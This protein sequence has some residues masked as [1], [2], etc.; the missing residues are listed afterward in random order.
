MTRRAR[1]STA[2]RAVRYCRFTRVRLVRPRGSRRKGN[3]GH[4]YR[5]CPFPGSPPTPL[6][7]APPLVANPATPLV[8]DGEAPP[9][10]ASGGRPDRRTPDGP[11]TERGRT[12]CRNR[13][14]DHLLVYG[15]RISLAPIRTTRAVGDHRLVRARYR[16]IAMIRPYPPPPPGPPAAQSTPFCPVLEALVAPAPPLVPPQWK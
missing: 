6:G 9:A 8:K 3:I 2:T 15:H 14:S 11:C 10:S 5:R 1:V 16:W 4:C 13:G 7:T 12:E